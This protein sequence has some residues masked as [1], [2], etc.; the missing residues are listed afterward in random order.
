MKRKKNYITALL[1]IC[2]ITYSC[3]KEEVPVYSGDNYLHFTRP[4]GDTLTLSFGLLPDINE[5][6]LPIPVTRIGMPSENDMQCSLT[7][8]AASTLPAKDYDIKPEDLIFRSKRFDDTLHVTIRKTA[9]MD[10]E[11]F[12]LTLNIVPNETFA[13]GPSGYL[14]MPVYVTNKV[15]QPAWWNVEYTNAFFGAYSLIKYQWFIRATGKYDLTNVQVSEVIEL[16]KQFIL[17]LREKEAELGMSIEDE[18]GRLLDT[19]T[20]R[21]I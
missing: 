9:E 7:A 15:N 10:N 8:D 18:N 1:V 17:F 2:L 13:Y 4:S 11:T 12:L 16:M 21:N 14:Q 5:Y 6:R 3:Q 20:Y 19:I